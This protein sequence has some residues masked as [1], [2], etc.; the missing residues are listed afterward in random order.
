MVAEHFEADFRNLAVM[1]LHNSIH[2]Q[3][4]Y[5]LLLRSFLPFRISSQIS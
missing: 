5:T 1:F 2:L 3:F 4:T